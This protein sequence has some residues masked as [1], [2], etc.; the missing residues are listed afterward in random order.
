V[1]TAASELHNA[2]AMNRRKCITE[3]TIGCKRFHQPYF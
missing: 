1:L 3:A 2:Q